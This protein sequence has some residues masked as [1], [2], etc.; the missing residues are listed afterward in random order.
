MQ[1]V[2]SFAG[3]F[4]FF[5]LTFIV[6][7]LQKNN[8]LIDV[9]WGAGFVFSTLVSFFLGRPQGPIALL[10]S[11][12]VIVWGVRLTFYLAKRNLGQPE[13]FRYADMRRQWNPKTFYLRMFVQIYLLQLGLNAVINLPVIV[14]N[15]QDPP[16]FGLV[17]VLGL[18]VWLVGFSFEVVGD[19]Q[20]RRFKKNPANK[21]KL[22][23][24]GLWRY[25]RHPNY[26]GEATLWWGLFLIAASPGQNVW[27]IVS[28]LVISLL[29]LFVSGV[30]L[31][32]R[33]YEGRAD[34]EAYKKK[35]NK[36]FPGPP[37]RGGS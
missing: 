7:Q 20:L 14:S 27:L 15:L 29:L 31:L 37:R 11:A 24:R 2:Y 33:K 22:I 4:G 26:F 30:P 8:G 23:Q 9:A 36:F 1:F 6:A 19:A 13:D 32:E 17:A 18:A 28:P 12:L 5:L 34:W 10:V 16:G 35:T 25:T 3:L 21:G